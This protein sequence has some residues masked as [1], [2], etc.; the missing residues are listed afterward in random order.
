MREQVTRHLERARLAARVAVVGTLTD[1]V[2]VV[3]SLVRTME[4]TH[5][6]KDLAVALDLPGE[7]RFRGERQ[8]LEEMVGNLVDNAFK[9]S[10]A[11]V[12]IEVGVE[13]P[14]PGRNVVRITVDDDGP[15]IVALRARAGG[16][17]RPAARRDQA[18]LGAGSFDRGGARRALRRRAQPRQFAD[19]RSARRADAAGGIAT[20]SSPPAS[21]LPFSPPPSASPPSST[22]PWT[23]DARHRSAP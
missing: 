1:V 11:R 13:N 23:P 12:G 8:D 21:P 9:W 7:A 16:A 15:G 17:A 14:E 4:K 19:R 22:I 5:H 3:Q 6:G 10:S 20:S 18:G 2:P